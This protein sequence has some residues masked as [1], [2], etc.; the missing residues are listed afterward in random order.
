MNG[1]KADEA[2]TLATFSG[3][4]SDK[5][6]LKR[7]NGLNDDDVLDGISDE[8]TLLRF[9]Q[10]NGLDPVKALEQF[11]Q[12]TE[13]HAKNDAGRLYDTI[14]V[15]DFEDTRLQYPHW[16]GRRDRQGRP[17]LVM[18]I[19]AL[20]RQTLAH[21]RETRDKPS[22]SPSMA[23][24]AVVYFDNLTR[25]VLPL[26]SAV[27]PEPVTS[28]VYIV[29]ASSLGLKQ[30]WDVREFAQDISWILATCYPETIHRVYACNCPAMLSTLWKIIKPFVD[31]VTASKIQFLQRSES[32][33]FLFQ[34]IE[35]ANIPS[36]IGGGLDFKTG[37]LPDLDD[38]TRRALD[39]TESVP[40]QQI[41]PGPLKWVQSGGQ[42]RAVATGTV[43]GKARQLNIATLRT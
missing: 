33:L 42:K 13:Y 41:P 38:E 30:S 43:D 5:G 32:Y 9:L 37:M 23:E 31:P 39:W 28:A 34:E 10:A 36:S 7:P 35:P 2:S 17:I 3:Q 22:S 4:C 18:D 20:D 8:T 26:C 29:D 40:Q 19:A 15:E 25:F 24:R 12:S 27:R 6:L 11:K 21:W 1:V 14:S 16:T